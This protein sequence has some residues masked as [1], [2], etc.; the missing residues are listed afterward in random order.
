MNPVIGFWQNDVNNESEVLGEAYLRL[1]PTSVSR[2]RDHV[3]VWIGADHPSYENV[4]LATSE[5]VTNAVLHTLRRCPHEL[6]LLALVRRA[7]LLYVEVLDP[8]G[9]P[10]EPHTP[11]AV[12]DD[13]ECGRGLAI[14]D[15]I[16][17]RRWG[18]RDHGERGR[19]VWCALDWT[20]TSAEWSCG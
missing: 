16:C 17:R 18:V 7:D 14:V 1:D 10:W 15:E 12:G 4:R 11:E 3:R 6:V 13:E 9:A 20:P 2:A 5:L 8:G 19:T